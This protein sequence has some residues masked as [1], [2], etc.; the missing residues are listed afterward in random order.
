MGFIGDYL[1]RNT[2]L[3]FTM[4]IATI[5]SLLSAAAPT[6]DAATVYAMIISFRFL[7]GVGLGGVY[8]LSAVKSAED[9]SQGKGKV[10]SLSAS[11]TFFWQM[12][13]LTAP[14]LLAYIISYS[15]NITT[16]QFWRLILGIGAISSGL[17]VLG[18][19]YEDS[20]KS[21]AT[22]KVSLLTEDALSQHVKNSQEDS[23]VSMSVSSIQGYDA[24]QAAVSAAF[25]N[26][27][28]YIKLLVSDRTVF[29]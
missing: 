15:T 17:V 6:G 7:M 29:G 23:D 4:A 1:G 2:G 8:P 25:Q 12:P 10:N 5:G 27:Q 19:L 11:W 21:K 14:W 16:S 13:A 18:L 3:A 24:V 20:L 26:R 22:L 28:T 9:A